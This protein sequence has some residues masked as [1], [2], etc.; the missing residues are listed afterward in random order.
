L[1]DEVLQ[2][3]KTYSWQ[4]NVRE[5]K[6]LLGSAMT[7]FGD[8]D[9]RVEHIRGLRLYE[10]RLVANQRKDSAAELDV[11]P[12]W[13]D[14]LRHLRRVEEFIQAFKQSLQHF[15]EGRRMHGRDSI[16]IQQAFRNRRDELD[17]IWQN[18]QLLPAKAAQ[19]V[20]DLREMLDHFQK[21]VDADIK[22]AFK[23]RE[24]LR[25]KFDRIL[26]VILKEAGKILKRI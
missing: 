4:G 5:L 13:M 11:E 26:Q 23:K 22:D 7:L 2:E 19:A 6:V 17:P 20:E 9:L 18:R 12:H 8:R 14:R 15:L 16:S 3:L 10:E 25:S 24:T 1:T 21:L